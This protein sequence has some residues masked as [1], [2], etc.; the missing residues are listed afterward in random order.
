[1]PLNNYH[2]GTSLLIGY[3]LRRRL[4]WPT[5]ISSSIITDFEPLITIVAR[6]NYPPH[7]LLHTFIASIPA[8]ALIGFILYLVRERVTPY[9]A[10]LS[11]VDK[12]DPPKSFILAGYCRLGFPHIL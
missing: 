3:L 12:K 11:L 8:G 5:L 2:L 10:D 4:N 1:M 7:D 9:L 6:L